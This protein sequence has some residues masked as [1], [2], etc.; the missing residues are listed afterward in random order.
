M[1]LRDVDF[2]AEER[3]T[4]MWVSAALE[5]VGNEV[6]VQEK[7]IQVLDERTIFF[8]MEVVSTGD[9]TAKQMNAALKEASEIL[10]RGRRFFWTVDL[11]ERY[12]AVVVYPYYASGK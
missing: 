10:K 3:L 12:L 2:D 11:A 5:A 4:R 8:S 9:V 6:V 7:V 1:A